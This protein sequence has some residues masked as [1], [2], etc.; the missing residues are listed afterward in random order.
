MEGVELHYNEA[1]K[2]AGCFVASA[3]GFDSVPADM[4]TLFTARQLA[5][6]ST[7]ESFLSIHADRGLSGSLP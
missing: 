2:E 6:P 1:A 4:G 7:V 3:C 5:V